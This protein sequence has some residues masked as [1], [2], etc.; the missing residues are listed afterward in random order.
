[1]APAVQG[2]IDLTKRWQA[3]EELR[4]KREADFERLG[5]LDPYIEMQVLLREAGDLSPDDAT[6][7]IAWARD[8]ERKREAAETHAAQAAAERAEVER[9]VSAWREDALIPAPKSDCIT[10]VGAPQNEGVDDLAQL[11]WCAEGEEIQRN[12]YSE[13]AVAL[14]EHEL[15]YG[16]PH[17]S[18]WGDAVPTDHH[19]YAVR[20]YGAVVPPHVGAA[21]RETYCAAWLA[22][23]PEFRD[24]E[25]IVVASPGQPIDAIFWVAEKRS[26]ADV[27]NWCDQAFGGARFEALSSIYLPRGGCVHLRPRPKAVTLPKAS[28]AFARPGVARLATGI[29]T[30]DR[31]F[32]GRPGIPAGAAAVI[33][34]NPKNGKTLLAGVIAQAAVDA[35]FF[36]GWLAIDEPPEG[37]TTRRLQRLGLSPAAALEPPGAALATLDAQAFRVTAEGMLEDFWQQ[38]HAEANGAPLLIVA[39]SLQTVPCVAAEGR[40][41]REGLEALIGAVKECQRKWPG[42]FLATSEITRDGTPKGSSRILYSFTTC[43]AVRRA[44]DRVVITAAG[45][46]DHGD[47]KIEL[48]ADFDGQRL[49]DPEAAALAAAD[50]V[51][52]GRMRAALAE[53][54]KASQRE[55]ERRLGGKTE[56]VRECVQRHLKAGDLKRAGAK[57]ELA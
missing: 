37:I 44:G 30:L 23:A 42:V 6:E 1:M 28:A 27:R 25:A 18:F 49:L 43:L 46:R 10:F 24:Q 7:E 11:L 26:A 29:G 16:Q 13:T 2:R 31:L 20:D 54:G 5:G 55:L 38:A 56:A 12:V 53:L 34:G 3:R 57:L 35:G 52:W 22:S 19:W 33:T 15:D 50:A 4:R 21:S 9:I 32:R 41:E 47:G 48:L 14:Y 36:V 51:L 40:G 17:R 8:H 45:G 39:D